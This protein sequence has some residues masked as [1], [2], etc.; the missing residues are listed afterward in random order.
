V[1][2]K[3]RVLPAV[4]ALL[5]AACASPRP[6]SEAE[7]GRASDAGPAGSDARPGASAP[8][9]AGLPGTP[10]AGTADVGADPPVGAVDAGPPAA[11]D[12]SLDRTPGPP[13]GPGPPPPPPVP[14]LTVMVTGNGAGQVTG[15]DG[16][17][18]CPPSCSVA[19]DRGTTVVL[20]A[21]TNSARDVFL[22]WSGACSGR[23][24][25]CSVSLDGDKQVGAQFDA[26]VANVWFHEG[27]RVGSIA[28][29][30]EQV[31]ALMEV[32][33]N[34]VYDG[35]MA[36]ADRR[37]LVLARFDLGTGA[38]A[39]VRRW[40][41]VSRNNQS[42]AEGLGGVVVGDGGRLV[43]TGPL[44]FPVQ[45]GTVALQPPVDTFRNG[46]VLEASADTGTELA[47]RTPLAGGSAR[48]RDGRIALTSTSAVWRYSTLTGSAPLGDGA[49]GFYYVSDVDIDAQG[50][51]LIGGNFRD[52]LTFGAASLTAP[53]TEG[54]GFVAKIGPDN[55]PVWSRALRSTGAGVASLAVDARG[56]VLAVFF[57][58]GSV[59]IGGQTLTSRGD[60]DV[61]VMK[62]SGAT[63]EPL[64][65]RSFGGP[66]PDY[67][68]HV[69]V[70]M[71][72]SI[73]VTAYVAPEPGRTLEYY[74][75]RLSASDGSTHWWDQFRFTGVVDP[76][77]E[78]ELLIGS[79]WGLAR[80]KVVP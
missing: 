6:G 5:A 80:V 66:E 61:G 42:V 77:S 71:D 34:I 15:A 14:R 68:Q 64:W 40:R 12:A 9:D 50:A 7:A 24:T 19:V 47:G 10:A 57:F 43:V 4:V 38:R 33:R 55:R 58:K 29:N 78:T 28:R 54:P 8:Q 22:G 79:P 51:L 26:R 20:T 53:P 45:F 44:E 60:D 31:Y 11:I 69:A 41:S 23:G 62:L 27:G 35:M 65:V 70:G 52:Q 63:G 1:V 49:W 56:D 67:P 72:G 75:G 74:L 39:W 3:P 76:L 17:I 25:S 59:S 16:R 37:D 18:A 13:D 48:R 73:Y 46:F 21:R 32:E 2:L 30:G 36:A